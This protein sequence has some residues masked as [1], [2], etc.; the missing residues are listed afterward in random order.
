MNRATAFFGKRENGEC[1]MGNAE[2]GMRGIMANEEQ[3]IAKSAPAQ[4]RHSP[5]SVGP[6]VL[7]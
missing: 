1:G 2:I 6:I 5:F 7:L 3:R 4:F